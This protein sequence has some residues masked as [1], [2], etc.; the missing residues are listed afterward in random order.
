MLTAFRLAPFMFRFL[1]LQKKNG[2]YSNI[3]FRSTSERLSSSF[4]RTTLWIRFQ[5]T[6]CV[7]T[8]GEN[9]ID[10]FSSRTMGRGY[11]CYQM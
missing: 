6:E 1:R 5:E 8:G 3:F 10:K 4:C 7:F 9:L 2:A 11:R